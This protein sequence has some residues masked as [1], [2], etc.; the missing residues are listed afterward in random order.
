MLAWPAPRAAQEQEFATSALDFPPDD[1]AWSGALDFVFYMCLW[2][3]RPAR[4]LGVP[5]AFFVFIFDDFCVTWHRLF[6]SSCLRG[7]ERIGMGR[8]SFRKD[9]VDLVSPAAVVFDD[10]VGHFHH[11]SP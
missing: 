3:V 8:E 5:A 10:F 6:L 11:R 9:T 4:G 2:P 1:R 7:R